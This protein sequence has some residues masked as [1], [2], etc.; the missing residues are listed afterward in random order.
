MAAVSAGDSFDWRDDWEVE[1]NFT[2]SID[3]EGYQFPSAIAF[4]PNPGKGPKDPLYF[5]TELR[6]KVK[7]VTND[8]TVYTFAE[9]FFWL[10]P[11]EELPAFTGES[12]LAGTCLDPANGYVFVTFAYQ[13]SNHI[14]R[15]NIIRFQSEPGT[16]SVKPTS[17]LAFTEIFSSEMTSPSHQIGPCQVYDGS[18]Y[19]TVGDGE[20]YS[21]SQNLDSLL[22]KII[23]MKL[24]GKPVGSN[25]FYV[26]DDVKKSRNYVWAYGFRN[27]FGLKIVDGRVFVADNGGGVDRFLEVNEGVNYLWDGND[28]SISANA[29]F[30]FAPSVGVVQLDYYPVGLD[31]FPEE[32]RGRFYLALCGAL[33][34]AGPQPAGGKSIVILDYGFKENKMLGR[35]VQFLKYKGTGDQLVVGLGIGPD[36]LYF[37]P[38]L[39]NQEGLSAVF[40]VSYDKGST[41]PYL[42]GKGSGAVMLMTDYGCYGCHM[43]N[44]WGWG[45]RGPNLD[46]E[47]LV[48]RLQERLNSQEY[49][50]YVKNLDQSGFEP[51]EN[52]V[53]YRNDV[54]SKEGMD[55]V[56]TWVKYHILEP[57]FD[58]P[59]SQ[60]PRMGMTAAE[61]DTVANYLVEQID[62][63]QRSIIDNLWGLAHG[64]LPKPRYRYFVYTFFLGVF[65]SFLFV[66]GYNYFGKHR[67]HGR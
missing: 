5:V 32:F 23:R 15:N 28:W 67:R 14:L 20:M 46:R 50:D 4:V 26:D 24:D 6:G 59:G 40:K 17:E 56:T 57:N 31:I 10:K 2:I 55:R 8:R 60:M 48:K 54:L 64:D 36:G 33:Q 52:S 1:E 19:V 43:V 21:K 7:V 51:Y 30:V 29:D 42:I 35:P 66:A 18:L 13:D 12:G 25:P 16:F 65:I 62:E 49:I 53:K 45:N 27:P 41:Y 63:P 39:P 61:A 34:L 22:G 38:L 44:G 37:A 3:T 47:P 11:K 9:D 58:N